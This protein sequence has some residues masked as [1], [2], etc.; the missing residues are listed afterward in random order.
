MPGSVQRSAHRSGVIPAGLAR[1]AADTFAAHTA[2]RAVRPSRWPE[3]TYEQ[4]GA[5]TDDVARGLLAIG[6][7]PGD[8]V[9]ILAETRP[10]WTV[11][12]LAVGAVGAISVPVY[13]TNSPEECHWV[14]SD[15][16]SSVLIC[17][18]AGQVAKVEQLRAELPRLRHI[19]VLDGEASGAITLDAL[20]ERGSATTTDQV[21]DREARVRSGDLSTIIYTSGTTGPPKGCLICNGH[22]QATLDG[23]DSRLPIRAGESIFLY[24]PLAHAFARVVQLVALSRGATLHF[25]GGDIRSVAADLAEVRP[26]YL[27]SAPLLFE[28]VH[29]RVRSLLA[30]APEADREAFDRAVT[31]GGRVRM[32]RDR[33]EPVDPEIEAE[34]AHAD[35]RWLSM[36]RD[37]FGGRLKEA[38]TGSAP[39]A[40]DILEFFHACGVPVNE[41]YGMTE[42]AAVLTLNSPADRRFG[43]VGR[44]L[45]GVEIRISDD[46][47]ILARG[48]NVFSG[49]HRAPAATTEILGDGWLHTGDLGEF[50]ADGYLRVTGRKKDL[51]IPAS[52]K[53]ISPAN[54]EGDLRGSRWISHAIVFGDRRPHLAALVTLDPDEIIPWARERGLPE[55]QA[56]LAA[57]PDVRALIEEVVA[58]VG[59][60]YSRPERVR[61]FAILPGDFS[62][63]TGELTPS[64]KLRRSIVAQRYQQL[65]DDLYET[66]RPA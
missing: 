1:F 41:G 62:V 64:L 57:H 54:I 51:I 13:P 60:R 48:A 65:L 27:P 50:D 42:S 25:F 4:L 18:D 45:P 28:K 26:D 43:T 56:E 6:V 23:L 8:R 21:V 63:E 58:D 17:E 20:L 55:D 37:V 10:E 47:E 3:L 14:L 46:G 49:Y 22:W 11:C 2:I 39:I 59:A 29:T 38:L 34:F 35:E 5:V 61:A 9:A 44:P 32:A 66:P 16:E 52:G 36:V 33:G 30:Q 15:S 40:P 19:V 12:D 24:L 31:L 53:N 7:A